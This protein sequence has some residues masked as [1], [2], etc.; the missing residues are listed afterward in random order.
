MRKIL[1]LY[2]ALLLLLLSCSRETRTI[3]VYTDIPEAVLLMNSFNTR[4]SRYTA[5]VIPLNQNDSNWSPEEGDLLL[6]ENIQTGSYL[7]KMINLNKYRETPYVKSIYPEL[8]QSSLY[9]KEL[10]LI[11]LSMDLPLI[12]S[13]KGSSPDASRSV[14]WTELSESALA[15][16]RG[17]DGV[18]KET[19]FS[20]LWSDDF[21]INAL[22]SGLNSFS[23]L[24]EDPSDGY[25]EKTTQIQEWIEE[26]N[27][28]FDSISQ[29]NST[30]RYIPDY[31]LLINGR[32][33]FSLI[34]LSDFMLLPEKI[35]K[36]LS[37]RFLK[38]NEDLQPLQ[39]L[40]AGIFSQAP[41]PEGAET[42]IQWLIEEDTWNIYY[43][44]ILQNR[45]STFA[46][47]G[48]SASYK[49]NETLLTAAYP[50][51][52]G[53]IPYPGELDRI[54]EYLPQ[55]NRVRKEVMLPHVH[56][57]LAGTAEARSL[58]EEYRKWL[59]QNPDP[60]AE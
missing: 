18:L 12:I 29:F 13:K 4:Q 43:N 28:G 49:I 40:S 48:I 57:V 37:Y 30:Y 8:I 9:G 44:E 16:N 31:R 15:F 20:P 2:T 42:L 5:E 55:W 51:L 24:M 27:G 17:E 26:Y 45:D 34:R 54:P 41:N 32:I 59:L 33:G 1:F 38:F 50:T 7:S 53:R 58:N 19:G 52:S 10:K 3:R 46:F 39:I 21:L 36:E 25:R 11:P 60:L 22:S 23:Q 35:S 47:Q 6:A 56:K 14:N